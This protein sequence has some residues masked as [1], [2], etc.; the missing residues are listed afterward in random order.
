MVAATGLGSRGL[1]GTPTR[2][3]GL[4]LSCQL[5]LG[6]RKGLFK[7][8]LSLVYLPH[9]QAEPA[10]DKHG[11]PEGS[12]TKRQSELSHSFYKIPR[13]RGFVKSGLRGVRDSAQIQ[14]V[15]GHGIKKFYIFVTPRQQLCQ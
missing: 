8:Y 10:K 2:A 11:H 1:W 12:Q 15:G 3:G 5:A 6:S 13:L 9:P 7:M 4:L 14:N